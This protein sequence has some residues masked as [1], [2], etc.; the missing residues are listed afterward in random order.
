MDEINIDGQVDGQVNNVTSKETIFSKNQLKLY[1]RSASRESLESFLIPKIMELQTT[2]ELKSKATKDANGKGLNSHD[3]PIITKFHDIIKSGNHIDSDQVNYARKLLP[4]YAGQYLE[5]LSPDQMKNIVDHPKIN[6]EKTPDSINNTNDTSEIDLNQDQRSEYAKVFASLDYEIN[7]LGVWR[8]EYEKIGKDGNLTIIPAVRLCDIQI[9]VTGRFTSN[10][11]SN[12][13]EVTFNDNSEEQKSVIV[14][15]STILLKERFKEHLVTLHNVR[16]EDKKINDVITYLNSCITENETCHSPFY[17]RGEAFTTGDWTDNTYTKFV[18]GNRLFCEEYVNGK[19]IFVEHKCNFIDEENS[20]IDK[21]L[22]TNGHIAEWALCV[23]DVAK[24]RKVRFGMYH[25]LSIMLAEMLGVNP[26]SLAIIFESS[27]GKTFLLMLGASLIG[28]P[29]DNGNG[30]ILSGDISKVALFAILRASKGHTVF[31]DEAN[32]S[33][34]LKKIIGYIAF[35]R[36]ESLRGRQDGKKRDTKPLNSNLQIASENSIVSDRASDGSPIRIIN[37]QSQPMP[38]LPDELV[39]HT[40][41]VIKQNYGHILPLFLDKISEHRKELKAWFEEAI[42]R[43]QN[44]STDT[45]INR[46]ASLYALAEV[47]GRLLEEIF[48]D[49][50][51]PP[52]DPTK[53]VDAMWNECVLH[54]DNKPLYVKAL[55]TAIDFNTKYSNKHFSHKK[56]LPIGVLDLHG[57]FDDENIYYIPEQLYKLLKE[58]DFSNSKTLMTQWRDKGIT[59]TNSKSSRVY[60]DNFFI[61][62]KHEL[63]QHR[64]VIC[65]RRS[66]VKELLN[67]ESEMSEDV[68]KDDI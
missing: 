19:Q 35:N 50:G 44:G 46:Q 23:K 67:N 9:I 28:N 53:V 10:D 61:D 22:L 31:I 26:C 60:S 33:E 21:I 38:I 40:K 16:I 45:V 36:Q 37:L 25:T 57:F 7:Q 24:Y 17:K 8:K 5:I 42:T 43:L 62:C 6:N 59:K 54:N 51:I 4:K 68:Y 65:I 29:N 39:R 14:P 58:A 3:A 11:D 56:Q 55:E 49:I 52:V 20:K 41:E 64:S 32:M 30:L 2:D 34:E 15:Q 18:S 12:Y 1:L 27:K 13:V 48:Q 63:A 47:A 66:K